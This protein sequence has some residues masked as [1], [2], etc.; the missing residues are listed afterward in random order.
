MRV[1]ILTKRSERKQAELASL[2]ESSTEKAISPML[3]QA[4][5]QTSGMP[6]PFISSPSSPFNQMGPGF[7]YQPLPR[8][9]DMFNSGFGPGIPLAPDAIDPLG[10]NGR[11]LPRRAQYLVAANLQLIDRRVP[12][13]VLRG[14]AEDVDVIARCIQIVQDALVGL[15][16]SWGFSTQILQQIMSE[17]GETNSAKANVLARDKY[18]DELDRVQQ[19]FKRPDKL[20]GYSFSQWLTDIIYSHLVYDGIVISPTYNLKG[21][22]LA[23]STIDTPT[24]KILLDNRGFRPQP[25]APAYQQ[26]LYGFPRG[27]FQMEEADGD[28]SVPKEFMDSQLAYYVRRP[29]PGSVYG[30]SQVE[31]CINIATVYMQRQAWLHAEYSH[32][33]T[34][35]MLITVADTDTWTPEQLAFYEQVFN[36]RMAGQ[37]Q[38]RQQMQLLRPGMTPH[39]LQ[40]M[41]E[42]YKSVYDEFLIMQIGAKFGI[43]QSQLGIT[44]KSSIGGGAAGKQQSDQSEQFA[45]DALRNF[46]IDCI[47]DC[48]RRFMGAGPELTI[49]A[50]GGGN[51]DDDLTRAQADQI[52]V[53]AGIRTRNEIRAER[54]VPL[55]SEPEADQL[56]ITT[57]TGVSFL[58][59]A[60]A[61]QEANTQATAAAAAAPTQ[62]QQ[63]APEASTD[64]NDSQGSHG[65]ADAGHSG[66][67]AQGGRDS[68]SGAG[69]A[70]RGGTSAGANTTGA[71]E[72]T[73]PS[74]ASVTPK[75]DPRQPDT[76]A[77]K[78]IAAF[79][80]FAKSRIDRAQWRDFRF[81]YVEASLAKSLNAAGRA[82]DT[83]RIARLIKG[84]TPIAA[85]IAVRAGDTGRVLMLQRALDDSDPASG[86]W[87]F[88]GGTLESG[89]N[90]AEAAVREWQEETGVN[91]PDGD[92]AGTWT[93][94]DHKYVGHIYDVPSEADVPLNVDG[95]SRPVAN[96][97]DP[98]GDNAETLAWM[99]VSDLPGNPAVRNEVQATPWHQLATTDTA[100]S[101][102]LAVLTAN[103][104]T[105][106]KAGGADGADA[107]RDWYN[108]GA[109]GQIDWGSDGDFEA[110]VAIAG[111]YIDNPEG[112]CN[113]R[114]QDA[115]GAPPGKAPGESAGKSVADDELVKAAELV[116][117]SLRPEFDRLRAAY[118]L[119][120]EARELQHDQTSRTSD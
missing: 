95:D 66:G 21:E 69:D 103:M 93:S 80:K 65:N 101:V 98:D 120:D 43:P 56:A 22:L 58:A 81:G 119:L 2:I 27:E 78:E 12:W 50:T 32:G 14:L 25:P 54:G 26:I 90:A 15:E 99:N 4:A 84:D 36:D 59:G 108:S 10:P 33:V 88:P 102:N 68:G 113:E 96:P 11:T 48:A 82:G 8:P 100:K 13:S 19:F 39:Q 35:K 28:G 18:G 49:T 104:H 73:K 115:T 52:D 91:L 117:V 61:A 3:A 114:H 76:D 64:G 89:E 109:D 6:A 1:P 41:D 107:L 110:C 62:G 5:A 63:Q 70:G 74:T 105:L 45:T 9:Q 72:S 71:G 111:K 23:L 67:D 24:I 29:H 7:G 34:P 92:V 55:I 83:L 57:G 106:A 79:Q 112:Y 16:W 118:G 20:M 94:P 46:L 116:A 97:D 37:N 60:L 47:N 31:E 38:R 75:D 87:E 77:A 17:T 53:S 51:D 30:Y 40:S 85:G 44:Q 42:A 86:K